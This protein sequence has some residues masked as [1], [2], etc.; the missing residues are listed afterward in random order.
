[1]DSYEE[2]SFGGQIGRARRACSA[3]IEKRG[4][5]NG[6]K[7][8]D[9]EYD[10]VWHVEMAR[11]FVSNN[12]IWLIRLDD[13]LDKSALWERIRADADRVEAQQEEL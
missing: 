11:D 5:E 9:G 8:Y 6:H 2:R 12:G 13:I 4:W 3:E 7:P 1:M 10:G